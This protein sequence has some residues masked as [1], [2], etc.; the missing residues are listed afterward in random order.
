MSVVN[1]VPPERRVC[2]VNG[3]A[4]LGVHATHP[5]CGGARQRS[6]EVGRRKAAQRRAHRQPRWGAGRGSSRVVVTAICDASALGPRWGAD[7]QGL[8][9]F[10]VC[11]DP[12][13]LPCRTRRARASFTGR[14]LWMTPVTVSSSRPWADDGVGHEVSGMPA[15]CGKGGPSGSSTQPAWSTSS[16]ESVCVEQRSRACSPAVASPLR[17]TIVAGA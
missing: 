15:C 12:H 5:V 10:N 3:G 2:R 9:P 8:I 1:T 14:S 7:P 16:H 13:P 6:K 4:G 11:V 17:S